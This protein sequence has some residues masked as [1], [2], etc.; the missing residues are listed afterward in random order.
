MA[1]VK[2]RAEIS[3]FEPLTIAKYTA[4]GAEIS[5]LRLRHNLAFSISR[6]DFF[7]IPGLLDQSGHGALHC[8]FHPAPAPDFFLMS[9]NRPAET[10]R[11]W[12]WGADESIW[13]PER[14]SWPIAFQLAYY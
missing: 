14:V 6:C 11:I 3:S 1:G 13:N 7:A 12:E 10:L 8:L 4:D 2:S 9:S 5:I